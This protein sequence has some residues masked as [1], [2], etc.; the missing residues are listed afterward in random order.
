MPAS[1]TPASAQHSRRIRPRREAP[2]SATAGAR[3]NSDD[4]NGNS[5]P[6]ANEVTAE[7][8]SSEGLIFHDATTV[9]KDH[10]TDKCGLS[11]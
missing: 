11:R 6:E 3:R 10:A 7:L 5:K 4:G 8:G 1:P 9:T 2:R